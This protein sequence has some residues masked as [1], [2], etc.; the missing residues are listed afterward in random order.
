MSVFVQKVQFFSQ[1]GLGACEI[2]GSLAA[3]TV[4]VQPGLSCQQTISNYQLH[5]HQH[6]QYRQELLIWHLHH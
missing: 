1:G 6:Q 5:Q 3:P 2:A 4:I